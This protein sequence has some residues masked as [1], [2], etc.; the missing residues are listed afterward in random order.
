MNALMKGMG[1]RGPLS[2]VDGMS[3]N[4]KSKNLGNRQKTEGRS[5]LAEMDLR[6][7]FPLDSR[8][9]QGTNQGHSHGSKQANVGEPH[10]RTLCSSLPESSRAGLAT[11]SV[12]GQTVNILGFSSTGSLS[13]P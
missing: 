1:R 8:V 4:E 2:A 12:K 7:V 13:Q 9:S 5:N 11:F 3:N 6:E 10:S